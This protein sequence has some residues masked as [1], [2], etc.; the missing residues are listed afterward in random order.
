M[1]RVSVSLFVMLL[2][3]IT[4]ADYYIY[5]LMVALKEK[6]QSLS[7]RWDNVIFVAVVELLLLMLPFLDHIAESGKR[8][9][10]QRKETRSGSR[11]SD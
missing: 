4:G 2:F 5:Q 6:D 1:N 9:I 10:A 8:A 7:V 11:Q 3:L